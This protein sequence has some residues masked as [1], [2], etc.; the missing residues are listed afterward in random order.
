MNM[1]L[2][3]ELESNVVLHVRAG[4]HPFRRLIAVAARPFRL[5]ERAAVDLDRAVDYHLA[6]ADTDAALRFVD[7]VERA[8]GHERTGRCRNRGVGDRRGVRCATTPSITRA[9]RQDGE[10]GPSPV[11]SVPV[12]LHLRT[13]RPYPGVRRRDH[14]RA[15]GV[16][17]PH[18]LWWLPPDTS[19]RRMSAEAAGA[20]SVSAAATARRGENVPARWR[21]CGA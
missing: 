5:R 1:S 8:V 12:W 14:D 2:P 6:E 11:G 20:A 16:L 3:D 10:Y 9:L 4:P 7:A 13:R 19:N 17:F 15:R 21:R 18:G